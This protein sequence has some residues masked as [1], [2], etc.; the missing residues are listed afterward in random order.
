MKRVFGFSVF[1]FL[2][3]P[4]RKGIFPDNYH[5]YRSDILPFS[6]DTVFLVL[7]GKYM[8]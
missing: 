6:K 2:D 3:A 7:K 8:L 5:P 4:F 1:A